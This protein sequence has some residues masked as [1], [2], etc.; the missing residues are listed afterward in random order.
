V[1]YVPANLIKT[2]STG[3]GEYATPDG[4]PYVGPY[5]SIGGSSFYKGKGPTK[6]PTENDVL[7]PSSN[8]TPITNNPL[9]FELNTNLNITIVN[10]QFFMTEPTEEDYQIGE[11]TRYFCKKR[12]QNTYLEISKSDYNKLDKKIPPINFFMWKPF[13]LIWELTGDEEEVKKINRNI[14][15]LTEKQN[16]LPGLQIFLKEDYLKYFKPK[17]ISLQSAPPTPSPPFQPSPKSFKY[18]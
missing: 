12:N 7:I 4:K 17:E 6:S 5:Y 15:I 1:P 3:G 13:T 10:P 11:F 9:S 16:K 14:T 8:V 18:L 2:G